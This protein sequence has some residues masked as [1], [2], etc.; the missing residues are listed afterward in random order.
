MTAAVPRSVMIVRRV[1]TGAGARPAAP[2]SGVVR[3]GLPEPSAVD[4]PSAVRVAPRGAAPPS[5]GIRAPGA[6]PVGA[7]TAV[8]VHRVTMP[9]GPPTRAVEEPGVAGRTIASHPCGGRAVATRRARVVRTGAAAAP[10]VVRNVAA[11]GHATGV[12]TVPVAEPLVTAERV[13]RRIAV[14]GTG[15]RAASDAGTTAPPPVTAGTAAVAR[16]TGTI[17]AAR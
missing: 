14:W 12:P 9:A 11:R 6:V 13:R 8:R 1:G 3:A 5:R 17:V 10:T 15:V 4:G 2:H 16:A 7:T